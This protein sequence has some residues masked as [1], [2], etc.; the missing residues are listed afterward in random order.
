MEA[1][2]NIEHIVKSYNET[3]LSH[4]FLV[5]T[6]NIEP[7]YEYIKQG[8]KLIN[9]ENKYEENCQ[10]CNLCYQIDKNSL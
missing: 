9:C 3:K 7:C 2:N 4:A 5:E 6:D 10:Q 8:I 1:V